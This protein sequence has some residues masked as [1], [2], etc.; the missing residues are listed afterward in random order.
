[1]KFLRSCV[2]LILA[3]AFVFAGTASAQFKAESHTSGGY[4]YVS[5]TGDPLG[6]RIYTLKNGLTVYLSVNKTEPRIQT[7]IAVR[8]GSK[9]DP[10]DATGLAHYLEHLLFKGTDKYGSLDYAKEGPYLDE[11]ESLY[12][13][14]RGT[15]D[16]MQ[17][18]AIY[19]AID[20]VSG[21]AAKWAIANEYDKML[22]ALGATG[23][24][25]FTSDEQTVYINDIPSNQIDKWLTIE[26]ERFRHPVLRLFHTELEAV[27]EEKNRG[28]DNDN[29]LA[30]EALMAAIFQ[31]HPYGQ[32]TTIG[33][34]EHLKNPSIKKIKEFYSKWYVP[35][36]MALVMS[37]D[38]DPDQVIRMID[39]HMSEWQSK[40]LPDW[41]SPTEVDLKQPAVREVYGPDAEFVQMAWRLPRVNTHEADLM[42]M[43][44]MILSN[45]TAGLI[46]LN[47]NQQ[48]KVLNAYSYQQ[49]MNDYSVHILGGKPK[50]GQSLDQVRDLLLSQLELVK[51]G[52]FDES[53]LPA[54]INDF[55]ISRLR[56]NE[57][58]GGRAFTMMDAFIR[59]TDW[60]DEVEHINALAKITKQEIVA[61]AN[62]YYGDD[63]AIVYKRSGE[64]RGIEKVTKPAITPVETN[65]TS[66]SSFLKSILDMPALPVTPH[67]LDFKHDITE[68]KL[69]SG[70]PV[71]YLH[72]NENDRFTL[73]YVVEMGRRNDKKLKYAL[74]YLNYLGTDKLAPEDIK[75][76]FFA[77]GSS[78]NVNA[79]NDEVS[80]SLTG[81]QKNF[82]PSV[83]LFES[84]LANAQPNETALKDYV[85]RTIKSRMDGKKN[86]GTILWS[87]LRNYAVYGKTNPQTYDLTNN[88]LQHL[89]ASELVDRIHTLTS[90][91]HRVLYYGPAQVNALVTVLD[92]R[93]HFPNAGRIAPTP[94]DYVHQDTKTNKVYFVDYDMAQAEVIMVSKGMPHFEPNKQPVIGLFNEYY[95]GSMASITFQTIRESKALAYA[96][97]S[98]YQVGNKKDEP[99]S[100]FA[101]VGSQADKSP[102]T[103][104]S[105]FELLNDMPRADKLFEQSKEALVNTLSTER[106][107]RE[108]ILFAYERAR[109]MGLDHDLRKD[110]FEQAPKL[111]FDD[112]EAFQKQNIQGHHY[113]IA[114][115][116]SKSK[117][118]MKDLAKYGDVQELSLDE[119]F[120]Y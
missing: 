97:W 113:T 21:V 67:F 24:N 119:I 48:Q 117:V 28:L 94:V 98:S 96:V 90:Y 115:L 83:E 27:Y 51:K 6:A 9:M 105:M 116:G 41:V 26:A 79:D 69:A 53:L 52:Q 60:T 12:E 75:K 8:A 10:P 43:M 42:Q 22:S 108:G 13:T 107:T 39:A 109:K 4:K 104:K 120:G 64:H 16:T 5:V 37:G 62:K 2:L 44:D 47:L 23:T 29:E 57:D 93:H 73:Y 95:G 14:Y 54:I 46:D 114:V 40:S 89:S 111:T 20:S 34:I 87:A 65:R 102:E 66:Q 78:F 100:I 31:K 72:N 74:D 84:L 18:K 70:I 33:T 82:A 11:I 35:N 77:L 71:Y 25:A 103:M 17:R 99:Y 36:N 38:F 7:M 19:H 50:E 91:K 3:S 81:L 55:T 58:N 61:F 30:N 112:I 68:T 56:T 63:Y 86:K 85:G 76:K 80:V 1:M 106:T 49:A 118:D 45:S 15:R 88:E 110:V 92:H 32:Q 59:H 101:Y